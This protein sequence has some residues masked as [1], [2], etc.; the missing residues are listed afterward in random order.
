MKKNSYS[1]LLITTALTETWGHHNQKAILLG[2][3]CKT[4]DNESLLQAREYQ[5]IPY[6]WSDR[7]KFI[8]D[9]GYLE[10]FYE[11]VLQSLTNS[12]NEYHGVNHSPRYWRMLLGPW[13]LT[14]VAIVWDRWESLRLAFAEQDFDEVCFL[15]LN[16]DLMVPKD[17]IRFDTLWVNDHWNHHLF[18][19]IMRYH[20]ADQVTIQHSDQGHDFDVEKRV[21]SY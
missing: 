2:E 3:W 13:L 4:M 11:R 8:K 20:Y 9:Y 5:Q 15:N 12:L 21:Q 1:P 19:E 6:H 16:R 18:S 7:D 10:S 14:Y 17:Y